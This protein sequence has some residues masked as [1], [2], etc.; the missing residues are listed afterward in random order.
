MN[1]NGEIPVDTLA[2]TENY[3]AWAAQE[4]DGERTYHLELGPVTAHFFQEEWEEFIDLIRD[5]AQEP[6]TKEDEEEA[7][8]VELDWGSLYFLRE[9]WGEFLT[10]IN[11]LG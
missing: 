5:A 3:T 8:E 9:E 2:E 6:P 10:L 7:I 4:P 11:Q 1:S